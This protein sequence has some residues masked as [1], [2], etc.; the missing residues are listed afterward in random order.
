MRSRLSLG[1]R[2][3]GMVE[4]LSRVCQGRQD[5]NELISNDTIPGNLKR[6][7]HLSYLHICSSVI[8]TTN[9]ASIM[10]TAHSFY[11]CDACRYHARDNNEGPQVSELHEYTKNKLSIPLVVEE[12]HD[13]M[14][15]SRDP[16]TPSVSFM[17]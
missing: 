12:V 1:S 9:T 13:R 14:N 17:T 4:S 5:Y 6:E 11:L 8:T 2:P 7:N 3:K 16:T 15:P 10:T